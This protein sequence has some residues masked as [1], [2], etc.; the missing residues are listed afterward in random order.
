MAALTQGC[1]SLLL[2]LTALASAAT[3]TTA[4]RRTEATVSTT[5]ETARQL[6]TALDGGAQHVL[7]T[8]HL[9][10]TGACDPFGKSL[11]N[12]RSGVA[13]PLIAAG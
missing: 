6:K 11:Y 7:I 2:A 8:E 4:Q 5:V 10:L 3:P 12:A 9:D 13:A 1:N